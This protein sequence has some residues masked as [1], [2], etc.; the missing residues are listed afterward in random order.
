MKN[1][2]VHESPIACDTLFIT[3]SKSGVKW[4]V[5]KLLL[6][7]S[8]QQFYNELIYSSDDGGLLWAIH[9]DTNDVIISDRM[10]FL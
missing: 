3:D 2:N 10:L 6:E 7:Y 4:R 9:D 5:P 1:S 8:M